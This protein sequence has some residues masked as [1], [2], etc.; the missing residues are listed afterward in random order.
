MKLE[1]DRK[2]QATHADVT[3]IGEVTIGKSDPR[4]LT[5]EKFNQSTSLL[6]H[7]AAQS[8]I[9]SPMGIYNQRDT[10]GDG[11]TDYGYGFY[12]TDSMGQAE[13][14]S[15]VRAQ[16]Q[17]EKPI[18]YCFLPHNASMLDIRDRDNLNKN[19]ILPKE[20]VQKWLEYLAAYI[21]DDANYAKYNEFLKEILI[22]GI[23]DKFLIPLIKALKQ[24]KDIFIR[25]DGFQSGIFSIDCNGL[26]DIIFQQFMTSLG[27]DGMIYREGGEGKNRE[28]LTGYIFYNYKAIDTWKGWESR[29]AKEK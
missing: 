5:K 19:G 10:G 23:K 27:Y 8:F 3:I 11:T 17:L 12:T 1:I 15:L 25:G 18:V 6:F 24:E 28:S 7:G 29:A 2:E 20:F 26:I 9:Y 22:E 13:N 14:Y 4:F 16:G 21:L